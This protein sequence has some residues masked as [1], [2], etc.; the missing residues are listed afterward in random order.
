MKNNNFGKFIL[1]WLGELVSSIGGGLTMLDTS[2]G[3]G[4]AV[5]IIFSGVFLIVT[6]IIMSQIKSIR[7][8][9]Q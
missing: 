6:A 9:S 7:Q 3:R 1:L 5:V 8:L 4:A 2:V